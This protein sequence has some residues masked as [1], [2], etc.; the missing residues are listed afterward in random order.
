[1]L[2]FALA[3][4]FNCSLLSSSLK[5]LLLTRV[6]W[7]GESEVCRIII[8][9]NQTLATSQPQKGYS[10]AGGCTV[11][12]RGQWAGFWAYSS[13]QALEGGEVVVVVE[14]GHRFVSLHP[15]CFLVILWKDKLHLVHSKPDQVYNG[16]DRS[17]IMGS[18]LQ[19]PNLMPN[20][21]KDTNTQKHKKLERA[22]SESKAAG[23]QLQRRGRKTGCG[24][25]NQARP[26]LSPSLLSC[27]NRWL[28]YSQQSSWLRQLKLTS[29]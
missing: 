19:A 28:L 5:E 25:E 27:C 29:E 2:I 4:F 18:S 1:M 15:T 20:P 12:G 10:L 17:L 16:W 6:T 14:L 13:T 8:S 26:L 7:W 3:S 21:A 22:Q 9:N 24:E 11:T 23:K